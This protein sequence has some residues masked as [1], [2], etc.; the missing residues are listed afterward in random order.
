[1]LFFPFDGSDSTENLAAYRTLTVRKTEFALPLDIVFS[2]LCTYLLTMRSPLSLLPMLRAVI[3]ALAAQSP[4]ASPRVY[5]LSSV[6]PGEVFT[7]VTSDL[8]PVCI[9]K[10]PCLLQIEQC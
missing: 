7:T 9:P 10:Q 8:H 3:G 5:S 6:Q 2:R 1:M 4:F